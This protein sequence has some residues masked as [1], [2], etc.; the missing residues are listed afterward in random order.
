MA[1]SLLSLMALSGYVSAMLP[2]TEVVT[3][4][5]FSLYTS[6]AL[7]G[8]GIGVVILVSFVLSA[9]LDHAKKVH[10]PD[11]AMAT[12]ASRHG[13]SLH[14]RLMQRVRR[15]AAQDVEVRTK[16][17][18]MRLYYHDALIFSRLKA[19]KGTPADCAAALVYFQAADLQEQ[20][21]RATRT[22]TALAISGALPAEEDGVE[23]ARQSQCD[24]AARQSHCDAEESSYCPSFI[25]LRI[26]VIEI[27]CAMR[28]L[29]LLIYGIVLLARYVQI[30]DDA[31]GP[32]DCAKLV[33]YFAV[34][35]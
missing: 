19:G 13:A 1:T 9:D 10:P 2:P 4:V 18:V 12:R 5:H 14:G 27:D 3:Y 21:L 26:A 11:A 15:V 28:V 23:A 6:Y 20:Q 25:Y 29:H 7:M 22:E 34:A 30:K 8:W 31:T 24:Q 33:S 35:D 16:S 17:W 32:F